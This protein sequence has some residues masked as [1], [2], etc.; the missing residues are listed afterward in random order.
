MF[1]LR[2]FKVWLKVFH[3]RRFDVSD[4]LRK[5]AEEVQTIDDVEALLQQVRYVE[6][7][8]H[9]GFNLNWFLPSYW[10]KLRI[11]TLWDDPSWTWKVK[12]GFCRHFAWLACYLLTFA[13]VE[14]FIVVGTGQD[15]MYSHAVCSFPWQGKWA[16]FS[17]NALSFEHPTLEATIEIHY[18]E[19]LE[20][21]WIYD[22]EG[23]L[24]KTWGK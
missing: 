3:P 20:C 4:G 23:R 16:Q 24:I 15:L 9:E 13:G 2:V 14:S 17:N 21:G 19:G 22:L 8:W 10:W 5:V 7:V 12:K 6:G 18:P 11:S 1:W